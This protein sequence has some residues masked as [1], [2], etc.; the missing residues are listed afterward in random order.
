LRHLKDLV[1][2]EIGSEFDLRMCRRTYGQKAIDKSMNPDTGSLLLW[3]K[4]TKTYYCRKRPD[5]AVKETRELWEK[6]TIIEPDSKTIE[7]KREVTGYV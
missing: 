3:H 7:N 4:T 2:K 1:Q 6:N 5:K